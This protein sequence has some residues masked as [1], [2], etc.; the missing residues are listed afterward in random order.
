MM[1]EDVR[2]RGL[3]SYCITAFA[4]LALVFQRLHRYLLI[5]LPRKETATDIHAHSLRC[6]EGM[7]L[8]GGQDIAK[9][10]FGCEGVSVV[11]DWH[12]IWTIPAVHWKQTHADS[13]HRP[14]KAVRT[15]GSI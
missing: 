1:S 9:L 5:S 2:T 4:V 15:H 10:D 6:D 3:N 8:D 13:L 11:D 12:S 14:T 7:L